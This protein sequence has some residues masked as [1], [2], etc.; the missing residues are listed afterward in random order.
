[1]KI[2]IPTTIP[3]LVPALT[4][5]AL[6]DSF[7]LYAYGDGIGAAVVSKR[8]AENATDPDVVSFTSSNGRLVGNPNATSSSSD[9]TFTDALLSI[10]GPDSN[11]HEVAFINSAG[12]S[13]GSDEHVTNKFV[14]Y[15]HTLLVEDNE[16]AYTS[17]FSAKKSDDSD[18]TYSLLWNV[19]DFDSEVGD[20]ITVS[21]RSVAPSTE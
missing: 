1:M 5:L 17:L 6:A 2:Q 11:S 19:T 12:S 18:G 13:S 4:G 16:G 20:V 8:K 10:P 14:W 7:N 3:I 9:P 15:G 21:M